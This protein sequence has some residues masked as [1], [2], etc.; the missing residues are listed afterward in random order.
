[1]LQVVLAEDHNIVRD[2][3]KMLLEMDKNINIAAEAEN[4]AQV[5]E[6]VRTGAPVD[7]ILAD[8]NMPQMDGLTLLK[9]IKLFDPRIAVIMLSMHDN[10]KYV[11][12][13]F[14]AGS[15]GY[16][17]KNVGA[18]ELI[19]SLKYVGAGGKYICSELAMRQLGMM[20]KQG[21]H[22][23][24]LAIDFSL[25]EIEVLHLIAEGQTNQEMAEKLFISKRTV[26]GH[27]QNLIEKTGSRNTAALIRYAVL[28][29]IIQ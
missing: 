19:F 5:M 6:F 20:F 28:N 8:I 26:E 15:S 4:G 12:Q 17:L 2:G 14:S 24:T 13:A 22:N 9:E 25:R 21:S 27:R 16:L 7:V 1:M 29:G 10:D 23:S 11:T 3:I 18:D